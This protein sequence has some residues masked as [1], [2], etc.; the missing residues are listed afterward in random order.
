MR[1][2]DTFC[3]TCGSPREA[4]QEAAPDRLEVVHHSGRHIRVRGPRRPSRRQSWQV[5][6]VFAVALVAAVGIAVWWLVGPDDDTRTTAEAV[7]TPSTSAP[8]V[9]REPVQQSAPAP[10]ATSPTPNY[11]TGVLVPSRVTAPS[12]SPDSADSGGRTTDY[13]AANV[14]DADPA[15]AWRMEG[16]GSGS[17]LTF[18]FDA[19][20][21]ITEVGLVNGFAK[22]DPY[23]GTDR[24][25]QGRR[26]LAVTWTFDSPT[27]PVT[28]QQQLVD[29]DRDLQLVPVAAVETSSVTLTIDAVTSPGAGG[30]FDRTAISDV[31]FANV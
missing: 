16:N 26:I 14:L 31:Q 11:P 9:P 23:D 1:E 25:E 27:G 8:Q 6:A 20:V 2:A 19:P 3:W 30:L 21:R 13:A 17:S 22:V 15:T 12:T 18:R 7:P 28:V 4:V 5:I 10:A 24:Y 29:G